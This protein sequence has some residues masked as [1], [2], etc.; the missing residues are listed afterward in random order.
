[1]LRFIN[2]FLDLTLYYASY[3][4]LYVWYNVDS[5]IIEMSLH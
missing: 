2:I 3:A 5:V 4:P 1:M